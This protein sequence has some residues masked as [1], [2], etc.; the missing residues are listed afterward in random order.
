MADAGERARPFLMRK[1]QWMIYTGAFFLSASVAL[2]VR[3]A[4]T[5]SSSA[6]AP[7]RSA[8]SEKIGCI[9]R[10]REGI[11]ESFT[12][13][14][15]GPAAA[16]ALIERHEAEFSTATGALFPAIRPRFEELARCARKDDGPHP[17]TKMLVDWNLEITKDEFVASDFHLREV[18]GIDSQT[19]ENCFRE[20]FVGEVRIGID[21]YSIGMPYS[22]PAPFAISFEF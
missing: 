13:F 11:P 5:G 18:L 22:G 17:Y 1:R 7:P 4:V 8:K 19:I 20:S 9:Q 15:K 12:R 16:V 2:G 6:L 10:A 3:A 21:N 14:M